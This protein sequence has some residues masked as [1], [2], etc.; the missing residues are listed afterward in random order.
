MLLMNILHVKMGFGFSAGFI[1]FVLNWQL[2]TNPYW[3]LIVGAGYFVLY[4]VTFRTYLHF[5]PMKVFVK[6]E[7]DQ[8]EDRSE[9]GQPMIDTKG[10]PSSNS[11][12]HWRSFKYYF[13]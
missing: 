5:F 13:H 9:A 8:Q 4:Y 6:E 12:A 3:I 10:S 7:T 2:A 1:D 11:Q